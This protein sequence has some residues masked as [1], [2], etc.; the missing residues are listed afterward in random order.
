MIWATNID[1]ASANPVSIEGKAIAVDST[2]VYVTGYYS[3]SNISI[4][5]ASAPNPV[6]ITP[7]LY[8]TM[9]GKGKFN[10]FIVAYSATNGTVVWATS[11]TGDA[12]S[13]IGISTYSNCLYVSG[14]YSSN[15]TINRAGAPV[16]GEIPV[17]SFGTLASIGNTDGFIVKY[18]TDGQI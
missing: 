13:G 14:T 1:D 18:R 5:S 7:T 2:N 10:C 17:D 8:G 3:S 16:G 4:N 6:V 15:I 12:V 11:I 9:I